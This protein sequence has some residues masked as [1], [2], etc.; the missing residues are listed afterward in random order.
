[1]TDF[2]FPEGVALRLDT[3]I[4]LIGPDGI[5]TLLEE[6]C[7]V[8]AVD[9]SD[10]RLLLKTVASLRVMQQT[11]N[12]AVRL[13]NTVAEQS[14]MLERLHVSDLMMSVVHVKPIIAKADEDV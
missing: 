5:A 3:E 1:M 4:G 7:N 8:P 12:Q 11:A 2:E 13:L 10:R 6:V 14:G 9:V